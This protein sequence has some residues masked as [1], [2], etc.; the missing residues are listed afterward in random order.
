MRGGTCWWWGRCALLIFARMA[1]QESTWWTVEEAR[2]C[3]FRW[4]RPADFLV[5]PHWVQDLDAAR[6]FDV[7]ATVSPPRWYLHGQGVVQPGRRPLAASVRSLCLQLDSRLPER[8]IFDARDSVEL[9]DQSLDHAVGMEQRQEP[10][11]RRRRSPSSKP[12]RRRSSPSPSPAHGRTTRGARQ[13]RGHNASERLHGQHAQSQ[14]RLARKAAAE[15]GEMFSPRTNHSASPR[16]PAIRRAPSTPPA[17]GSPRRRVSAGQAMRTSDKLYRQAQ[18]KQADLKERQREKQVQETKGLFTPRL[19]APRQIST[20][21]YEQQKPA[22]QRLHDEA[23]AAQARRKEKQVRQ[24]EKSAQECTFTP[25]IQHF[26]GSGANVSTASES[27]AVPVGDRLHQWATRKQAEHKATRWSEQ[28]QLRS[29]RQGSP[30]SA[31]KQAQAGKRLH[32]AACAT[33]KRRQQEEMAAASTFVPAVNARPSSLDTCEDGGEM[34]AVGDRLYASAQQ[35]RKEIDEKR[36]AQEEKMLEEV[37]QMGKPTISPKA[38]ALER[39]E[40]EQPHY[41]KGTFTSERRRPPDATGRHTSAVY[42]RLEPDADPGSWIEVEAAQQ[43]R[44]KAAEAAMHRLHALE[45]QRC[46]RKAAEK[47]QSVVI[48]E[49]RQNV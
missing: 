37:A 9:L 3:T 20:A 35:K 23:C 49:I 33:Q 25:D 43:R 36:Q 40:G 22:G 13:A 32:E 29:K 24:E 45:W 26:H 47:E 8:C 2:G 4:H 18:D 5:W 7:R 6:P 39:G 19:T 21:E 15:A 12:R 41:L 10:Q 27:S 16:S 14:K 34:L 17:A 30:L 42:R 44:I 28:A 31:G 48:E 46:K 11:Q 38:Q 1:G